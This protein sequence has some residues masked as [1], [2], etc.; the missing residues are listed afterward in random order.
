MIDFVQKYE[1]YINIWVTQTYLVTMAI[2]I[3][4]ITALKLESQLIH[5]H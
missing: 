1:F 5:A 4:I 2:N 3:T